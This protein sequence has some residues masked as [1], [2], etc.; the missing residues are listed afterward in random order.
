V[1]VRFFDVPKDY[2]IFICIDSDVGKMNNFRRDFFAATLSKCFAFDS[3]NEL[4]ADEVNRQTREN[5]QI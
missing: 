1:N 2:G 5:K 3:R 4:D